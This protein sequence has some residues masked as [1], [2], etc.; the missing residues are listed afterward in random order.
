MGLFGLEFGGGKSRSSSSSQS[1]QFDI[2]SSTLFGP[3]SQAF[4]QLFPAATDLALNQSPIAQQQGQQ[5]SSQLGG[6]G[7]Q[8]LGQL[9]QGGGQ[10]GIQALQ[11][12]QPQNQ[13]INPLSQLAGPN[14]GLLGSSFQQLQQLGQGQNQLQ[15]QLAQA[16]GSNPFLDEQIGNLGQDITQQLGRQNLQGAQSSSLAGQR[17]GA[18][19]GVAEGL[20]S[21]AAIRAFSQG[22][23]NLR[24][25]D[26]NL[27]QQLQQQGQ[28]AALQSQ[29]GAAGQLAGI[30]GQAAGQLGQLGGQEQLQQLQ[31]LIA[32]QQGQQGQQGLTNQAAGIGL[33]SLGNLFNLGLGGTTAGFGPLAALGGLVSPINESFSFG[34]GSSSSR[35]KS[36]AFNIDAGL[37]FVGG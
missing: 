27:Q 34:A 10:G 5:L 26:A 35:S 31:A 25:Q 23:G 24:F 17:G 2:S 14:A 37:G 22:A 7:Q 28:L 20:A 21:E 8:F 36:S 12:F 13:G 3:Q 11:Q 19:Q 1:Q 30:Q 16:P 32:A 29:Q 18:R 33:G 15:Q 6:Q 4:S 9:Q